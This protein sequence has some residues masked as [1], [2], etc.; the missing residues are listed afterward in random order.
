MLGGRPVGIVR[1][2]RSTRP[3]PHGESS[4]E[5]AIE[6][7]DAEQRQGIGRLLLAR[8]VRS[9]IAAGVECLHAHIAGGHRSMIRR[10]V[11]YGGVPDRAD[12][13]LFRLCTAELYRA[14][15]PARPAGGH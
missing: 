10:V 15:S 3:D 5:L 2:I 8:A 6:V 12:P 11:E 9:A 1:W 4:A 7:I 14:T 13:D